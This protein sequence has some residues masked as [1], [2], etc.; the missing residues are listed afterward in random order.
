MYDLSF[1][2]SNLDAI[3]GRL[4]A[5]GFTLNVDELRDL[6]A[7]RRTAVTETE[8]LKALRNSESA[9][10]A[11][12]RKQGVDTA[13]RQQKMR[14]IGSRIAGIDEQVARLD[15]EFRQ[16]LASVPNLPHESVPEGRSEADNVEI[17]RWGQPRQFD[18]QPKAHWDLGPELGILDMERAAKITGARFAVYFGLG[19]KLERR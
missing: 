1:F 4:R 14:D 9:E 17:H 12:L 10:I 3:A 7:R 13:E 5:R 6:D 8:Q 18:F 11:K 2:R 19:A 15:G 16:A